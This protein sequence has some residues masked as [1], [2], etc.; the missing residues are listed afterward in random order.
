MRVKKKD[1]F[2]LPHSSVFNIWACAITDPQRGHDTYLMRGYESSETYGKDAESRRFLIWS[3][4][5]MEKKKTTQ[6]Y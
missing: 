4:T 2:A 5:Q 3:D 6:K 1:I